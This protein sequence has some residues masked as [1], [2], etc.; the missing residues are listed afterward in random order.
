M[1][2]EAAGRRFVFWV[3][4]I[5][6]LLVT[7]TRGDL[8]AMLTQTLQ[9]FRG[10][11]E[12]CLSC[13]RNTAWL[14]Y[15]LQNAFSLL[16]QLF[17][18]GPDAGALSVATPWGFADAARHN[19]LAVLIMAYYGHRLVFSLPIYWLACHLFRQT[20]MRLAYVLAML[21][22]LG[23]W[24]ALMVNLLFQTAQLFVDWPPSYYLFP[25]PILNFDWAALGFVH[26]LALALIRNHDR[27]TWAAP[28]YAAFGQV[29]MDNLGLVT[30][31]AFFLAVW[32]KGERKRALSV[33]FLSGL[34]SGLVLATFVLFG[35]MNMEQEGVRAATGLSGF[36]AVR[37]WLGHYWESIGKYNFLWLNVTIANLV[38]VIFWP[39]MV[40]MVMGLLS[41]PRHRDD[42]EPLR[43]LALPAVAFSFSLFLA[44]FKSGLGSDMGR[45]ALPLASLLLPLSWYLSAQLVKTRPA[46]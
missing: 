11:D 17:F 15:L 24:P 34:S 45:Q 9:E 25:H 46:A 33:L 13:H 22:L 7:M 19:Q 30:G 28:A 35:H 23:G 44:M 27:L 12:T 16:S 31:I 3:F 1:I 26:L 36:D 14:F 43:A 42:S 18:L 20:W 2:H 40:G 5:G 29:M 39:V 10:F 8:A 38:S 4:L 32:R 37:A 41:R 6:V 21:A